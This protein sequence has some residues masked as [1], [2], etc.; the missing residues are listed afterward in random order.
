MAQHVLTILNDLIFAD[1]FASGSRAEVPIVGR[2][3]R[4][5]APALGVAGQV[6]RL[7]V[8]SDS[9]L[10]A[11][12]KTDRAPPSRPVCRPARA[13]PRHL[14]RRLPGENDSRRTHLHRGAA[15]DR[16]SAYGPGC[17]AGQGAGT[18]NRRKKPCDYRQGHSPV[19][20]P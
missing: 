14:G 20:F 2:L 13:L 4:E 7:A 6:D 5:G 12:Y 11:D 18:L 3:G 9:V 17:C 19:K 1:L 8:T 15:G 16:A 10:M